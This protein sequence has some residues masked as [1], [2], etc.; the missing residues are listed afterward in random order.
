MMRPMIETRHI[1]TAPGLVFD[2]T[3]VGPLAGATLAA[4]AADRICLVD[5]GT[6]KKSRC[7]LTLIADGGSG[8]MVAGLKGLTQ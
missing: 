6:T 8:Y 3:F 1:E 4:A 5:R 2:A 7:G